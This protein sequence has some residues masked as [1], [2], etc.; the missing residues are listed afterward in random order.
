MNSE[1]E[2]QYE[3][4]ALSWMRTIALTILVMI[5]YIKAGHFESSL[6]LY[7]VII[8]LISIFLSYNLK[9]KLL[10][11]STLITLIISYLYF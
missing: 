10:L 3:R 9:N 6:P 11:C 1:R 8:S 7:I 4:T 5:Y 2:T